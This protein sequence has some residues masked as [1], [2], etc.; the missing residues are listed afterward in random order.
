MRNGRV[1]SLYLTTS[2]AARLAELARVL[3]VS[4]SQVMSRLIGTARVQPVATLSLENPEAVLE[5][6]KGEKLAIEDQ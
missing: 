1:T 6:A 2:S 5:R 3:G 4:Q